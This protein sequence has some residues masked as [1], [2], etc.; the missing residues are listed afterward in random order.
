MNFIYKK[1]LSIAI[2]LVTTITI[3]T[4]ALAAGPLDGIVGGGSNP[5]IVLNDRVM[6]LETSVMTIE[7]QIALLTGRITTIE[8]LV[9]ANR[10]SIASLEGQNEALLVLINA[11]ITSISDI[12]TKI[13]TLENELKATDADLYA[14]IAAL[15]LSIA[16]LNSYLDSDNDGMFDL[17]SRLRVQIEHNEM[18]IQGLHAHLHEHLDDLELTA[19]IEN[20]E[21]P[22]GMIVIGVTDGTLTCSSNTHGGLNVWTVA[23]TVTVGRAENG[24]TFFDVACNSSPD[25][26]F[27]PD[28]TLVATGSGYNGL[29]SSTDIVSTWSTSTVPRFWTWRF[30]RLAFTTDSIQLMAKCVR[31]RN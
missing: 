4:T 19:N 12:R 3:S 23:K 29:G 7:Q 6:Q 8:G 27:D 14:E 22:A 2:L 16:I 18:L 28:Y 5:W 9:E 30:T 17:E 15:K 24:G 26:E 25:Y 13:A 31:V 21:C 1:S 20:Q 11:N 10:N